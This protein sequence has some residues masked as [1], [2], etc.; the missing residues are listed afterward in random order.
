MYVEDITVLG[1][2]T[3]TV[4]FIAFHIGSPHNGDILMAAISVP[5]SKPKIYSWTITR[6]G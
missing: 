2:D 6:V 5:V 3:Q 1:L 4:D